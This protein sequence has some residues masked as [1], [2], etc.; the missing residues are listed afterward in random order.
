MH[1]SECVQARASALCVRACVPTDRVVRAGTQQLVPLVQEGERSRGPLVGLVAPHAR[2]LR[3]RP[4]L[5]LPRQGARDQRGGGGGGEG[6]ATDR[7]LMA[8]YTLEGRGRERK[9][10]RVR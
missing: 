9:K 4:H 1:V 5:H 10:E 7:A 2:P 6:E 3:H 8:R